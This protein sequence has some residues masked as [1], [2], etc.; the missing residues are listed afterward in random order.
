MKASKAQNQ[1]LDAQIHL[2]L[3]Q[4]LVPGNRLRISLTYELQLPQTSKYTNLRPRPLGYTNL[5]PIWATWYPYVPPYDPVRG[6]WRMMTA[7]LGSTWAYAK[8][9]DFEVDIRLIGTQ[10][11]SGNRGSSPPPN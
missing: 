9:G 1:L 7:R 6:C 11:R 2:S 4:P 10:R 5:Q 8:A 3:R